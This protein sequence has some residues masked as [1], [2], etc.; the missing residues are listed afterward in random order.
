[1]A[2]PTVVFT[3]ND[4]GPATVT[5]TVP[6]GISSQAFIRSIFKQGIVNDPDGVTSYPVS[7]V[8][9]AVASAPE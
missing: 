1:M 2:Q 9:S 8:F 7:A 4:S 6:E 5:L 3:M